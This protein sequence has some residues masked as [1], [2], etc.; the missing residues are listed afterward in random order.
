[1]DID[2]HSGP[3]AEPYGI[4]TALVSS[5]LAAAWWGDFSGPF[6]WL[7][8][9][10]LRVFGNYHE[11]FTA[12]GLAVLLYFPVWLVET[13]VKAVMPALPWAAI[14]EAGTVALVIIGS[15]GGLYLAWW[16]WPP[17]VP[18]ESA[19]APA[20]VLDLEWFGQEPLQPGKWRVIGAADRAHLIIIRS[21]SHRSSGGYSEAYVPL[22]PRRGVSS[23]AP[24]RLVAVRRETSSSDVAGGVPD[25]PEGSLL[26]Q[27]LDTRTLYAFKRAGVA[28]EEDAWLLAWPAGRIDEAFDRQIESGLIV[29]FVTLFW[30]FGLRD[31]LA[32]RKAPPVVKVVK[33]AAS[34]EVSATLGRCPR[35]ELGVRLVALWTGLIVLVSVVSWWWS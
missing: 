3:A 35:C 16:L 29:M 7:V 34:V 26:E 12:L 30:F 17:A 32:R 5:V 28:V 1:M 24:A 8:D 27:R 25:D 23:D 13:V 11:G 10:E 15:L 9:Q 33:P 6:R 2:N 20:H 18:P 19:R 4:A 14:F 21:L 22:K 31:W